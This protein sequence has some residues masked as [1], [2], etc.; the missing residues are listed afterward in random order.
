MHSGLCGI[1]R[2]GNRE[3]LSLKRGPDLGFTVAA[4]YGD[5][6]L[7]IP[8]PLWRPDNE[9]SPMGMDMGPGKGRSP[10]AFGGNGITWFDLNDADVQDSN[11]DNGVLIPLHCMRLGNLSTAGQVGPINFNGATDIPLQFIVGS[12]GGTGIKGEIS[13]TG[14]LT[15]GRGADTP[16]YS[17][18][19]FI[20]N[21]AANSGFTARNSTDHVEYFALSSTAA[22]YAGTYTN[23]PLILRTNNVDRATLDTSG[24]MSGLLSLQRTGGVAVQGSNTN[25]SAS[26]GFVGEYISS[27][28]AAG[29]ALAL[30]TG[31]PLNV[32]SISLTAGDWTVAAHA[33]VKM[34]TSTSYTN[35]NY[36]GST[37]S[38]TQD[39]TPGRWI[40]FSTPAAVIGN[41]HI[42]FG[43]VSF[44]L[45]LASTTTVYLVAQSTFTVS[46]ADAWGA[47]SGRRLR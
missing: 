13:S 11:Y 36:S 19:Q 4:R 31:T 41:T 35:V 20:A 15:M 2:G 45:S 28:I 40:N 47:I 5:T 12:T 27:T 3:I 9:N 6:N 23:H 37:T 8:V 34:G 42:T 43:A 44:R 25:D 22:A 33:Y 17:S 7:G 46:T 26:A 38:A 30:T 29:S 14:V 39:F 10:S 18:S 16:N 1:P 24:N 21:G 32:T